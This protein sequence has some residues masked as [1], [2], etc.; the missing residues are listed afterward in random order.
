MRDH[1][2]RGEEDVRTLYDLPR[3]DERQIAQERSRRVVLEDHHPAVL[4]DM[5]LDLARAPRHLEKSAD[6]RARRRLTSAS[7][8]TRARRRDVE[9]LPARATRAPR[10]IHVF[11]EAEERFVEEPALLGDLVDHLPAVQGDG[12]AHA[13]DLSA[14]RV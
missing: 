7:E 10:D 6:E 13:E 11:S 14:G 9:S 1:A 3:G 4:D 12:S 8:M 5:G 2:R